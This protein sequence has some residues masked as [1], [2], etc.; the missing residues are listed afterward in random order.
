MPFDWNEEAIAQLRSLWETGLSTIGIGREMGISKNS[1]VGKAQRLN[2]PARPSP[3]IRGP[4]L[5]NPF[6]EEAK[7][8]ANERRR[9]R[10]KQ[11]GE[12]ERAQAV[13]IQYAADRPKQTAPKAQLAT[14]S[15]IAPCRHPRGCQWH[16]GR[17]GL[18]HLFCGIPT[19]RGSWCPTHEKIVF[20]QRAPLLSGEQCDAA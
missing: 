19:E 16:L 15:A 5:H 1:V 3:I 11:R 7:R 12:R 8:L 10:D 9:A 13:P 20:V 4:Q 2:L 18:E 6:R 17:R 14:A